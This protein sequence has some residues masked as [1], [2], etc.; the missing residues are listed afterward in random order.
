MGLA[1]RRQKATLTEQEYAV[2][3]GMV[4]QGVSPADAVKTVAQQIAKPARLKL[5]VEE[6]KVYMA[7]R[8]KGQS[9]QAASE[10]IAHLRQMAK[11]LPSTKTVETA[12]AAR[13][14][15]GRWPTP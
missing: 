12:V 13:N 3:E 11:G 2:A 15:T 10:A 9:H 14:A 8:G 7:L 1:A 6:G 5:N 4:K